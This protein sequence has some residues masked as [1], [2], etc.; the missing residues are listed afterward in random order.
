M[1][2]DGLL[3][4]MMP[5]G[6][7]EV[8][9]PVVVE[10]GGSFSVTMERIWPEGE[11][12]HGCFDKHSARDKNKRS[13]NKRYPPTRLGL[14]EF[15]VGGS[16]MLE[17]QRKY[18]EE[19]AMLRAKH[20]ICREQSAQH[21]ASAASSAQ[22]DRNWEECPSVAG[23]NHPVSHPV[24]PDGHDGRKAN[25]KVIPSPIPLQTIRLKG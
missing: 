3:P 4:A 25:S 18:K 17:M 15:E 1:C 21:S 6:L 13:Q 9:E 12:A 20:V 2:T 11:E 23:H 19:I 22:R 14:E 7:P 8:Y 5:A 10:V 24:N 16:K